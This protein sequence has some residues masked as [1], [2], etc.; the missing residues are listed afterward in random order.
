M[1]PYE[2]ALPLTNA[3][4]ITDASYGVVLVLCA[5]LM[6]MPIA[7]FFGLLYSGLRNRRAKSAGEPTSAGQSSGDSVRAH[8]EPTCP[9]GAP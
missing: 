8:D 5:F 3:L 9:E 2:Q 7:M 1:N 4:S 6:M